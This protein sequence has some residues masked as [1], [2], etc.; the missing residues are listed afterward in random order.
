M[1]I[2][3]K[4]GFALVRDSDLSYEK[5]TVEIQYRDEQLVQINMDKGLDN[6][7]M[8]IFTEFINPSFKPKF[9]LNDFL[10]ALNEARKIL[11]E[12]KNS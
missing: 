5:M 10:E 8:E 11:E 9:Q 2:N 1:P 4:S 6:L 12:Y 7:E 3:L